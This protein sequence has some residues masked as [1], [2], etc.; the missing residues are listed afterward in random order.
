MSQQNK[1]MELLVRRDLTNFVR[2]RNAHPGD[3]VLIGNLLVHTF[4][5]T[6]AKK[7]SAALTTP[8]R[9]IE[10]RNVHS[11]RLHGVVRVIELGFQIIGSH[12]LIYPGSPLDESWTAN[13]CTLRCVAI[14]P[15]FHT[16]R[17]SEMLIKDA[18]DLARQWNSDNVCLHVQQGAIGVAKL[19]QE[20]G[21]ERSYTGDKKWMGNVIEGYLLRLRE[22][23]NLLQKTAD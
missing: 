11:R 16:L 3:D 17:L 7:L 20:F 6:N 21:F 8:D 22:S 9:E 5:E 18:V 14:D 19:Y 23:S 15:N 2:L 12:S 1:N 4:R 10:L 13:T